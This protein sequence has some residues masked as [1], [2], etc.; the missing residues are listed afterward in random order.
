M[1][2]F[3]NL[4]FMALFLFSLTS[5]SK[6]IYLSKTLEPEII[7]DKGRN[8]IVFIN[9]FDYTL[10]VYVK[11]KN[12]ESYHAGVMK[13]TEGLTSSFSGDKSI[14]FLIG[15]TLKKGTK[16][17]SLTTLLPI[18]S[19]N[20]ICA[21]FN[22]NVLLA[23]DSM[24]IFF[25]WETIVDTDADGSKSKTKNFYLYADYYL[26]LY[27]SD[28]NLINRSKTERSS[29]YKSRPTLSGLITIQPSMAKAKKEIESLGLLAGKEY[30][31]KFYPQNVQEP[32]Q[33]YYGKVFNESNEYINSG[34]WTK[35]IELLE[36]LAESSD[37][38][39]AKKARNNLDV[40]KEAAGM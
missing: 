8:D 25:D 11:E 14:N 27:S 15:D 10:P 1:K 4:L 3:Q 39:I 32:R 33:I 38:K 13:L 29:F 7:L 36:K 9:L 20:A 26:S 12:E 17:G 2:S 5:C 34:N 22:S 24:N 18:D 37:P 16:V 30:A 21:R 28:G 31:D 40:A 35:A 23:L 19:I 6:L